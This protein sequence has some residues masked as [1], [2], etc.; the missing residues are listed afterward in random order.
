MK[1]QTSISILLVSTIMVGIFILSGCKHSVKVQDFVS[2]AYVST[3]VF[4]DN[5]P[6]RIDIADVLNKSRWNG[7]TDV[8][9]IGN[10][11]MAGQDGTMITSWNQENW[12]APFEGQYYDGTPID[13]KKERAKLLSERSL[14]FLSDYFHKKQIN[15]WIS[16]TAYG[17][18]TGGS[19]G[20]VA[21][22][23][24]KIDTF[25]NDVC[26]LAYEM[27]AVGVDFDWE[28]PMNEEESAGYRKMFSICK[29][30][31]LKVSV[32]A[33]RPTVDPSRIE[34]TSFNDHYGK[35]MKW[36]SIIDDALVDNINVMNYVALDDQN[37]CMSLEV[38]KD[39]MEE[40]ENWYPEEFT[41]NKK[42]NMMLGI[43]YYG[44]LIPGKGDSSD[45]RELGMRD[46]YEMY[47]KEAYDTPTVAGKYA[48]WSPSDVR[49]MVRMAY[50]RGWS[51]VFTWLV[52][53]DFD[54]THCDSHSLQYALNQEMQNIWNE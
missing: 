38:K 18:L 19:L 23:E 33:I 25:M 48:T 37:E 4:E 49:Q 44:Y 34:D 26:T 22:D 15:I 41:S 8:V 43:G 1:P 13:E 9:L 5:D 46:L 16:V 53:H 40:W 2:L 32:C 20:E 28:F 52:T 21:K 12:P 36:E 30:R 10:L 47:G 3:G 27:G 42:V 11:F 54:K 50:E 45:S 51:G 24:S 7:I 17:W 6:S 31:G 14:R 29:T 35:Y 39:L